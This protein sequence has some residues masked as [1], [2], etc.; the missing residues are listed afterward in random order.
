M[1][2]VHLS[3]FVIITNI[4]DVKAIDGTN[5]RLT[6]LESNSNP[7]QIPHIMDG[8]TLPNPSDNSKKYTNAMNEHAEAAA[9][10]KF[11]A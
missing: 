6:V 1:S 8:T 3:F 5:A 10:S 4:I 9:N 7:A 11:R 2:I